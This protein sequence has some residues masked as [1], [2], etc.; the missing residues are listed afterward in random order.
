MFVYT[1]HCF[2]FHFI[3]A[4]CK[5]Y[6]FHIEMGRAADADGYACLMA[7]HF[8]GNF[9]SA[10]RPSYVLAQPSLAASLLPSCPIHLYLHPSSVLRSAYF[11]PRGCVKLAPFCQ[12]WDSRNLDGLCA[13][14]YTRLRG[15]TFRSWL[16]AHR[17][18]SF[19]H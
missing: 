9:P 14:E 12:R 8:L 5:K 2:V 19:E 15:S 7:A 1:C 11:F 13:S 6:T 4:D 3:R 17:S 10:F 18:R 16:L